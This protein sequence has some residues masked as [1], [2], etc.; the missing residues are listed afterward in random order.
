MY[1]NILFHQ[2]NFTSILFIH[3]SPASRDQAE[4]NQNDK[5]DEQTFHFLEW[6]TRK[7]M[8]DQGFT[9]GRPIQTGQA[10]LH[11][12]HRTQNLHDNQDPH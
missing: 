6:T 9:T 10:L 11:Q 4:N 1:V 8:K 5:Y 2:E 7:H 3:S 12:D